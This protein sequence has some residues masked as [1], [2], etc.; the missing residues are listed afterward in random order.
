MKEFAREHKILLGA[1]ISGIL[2]IVFFVGIHGSRVINPLDTGLCNASGW[3][4]QDLEQH[5]YGWLAFRNAPWTFP[6]GMFDTVT[7][8][9][10]VSMI[11]ADCIPL[12]AIIGKLFS[13]VLPAQFQYFGIYGVLCY[14]LI[15]LI[16]YRILNRYTKKT[17]YS[18][19]GS[20]FFLIAPI[21]LHRTMVHEALASQWILLWAIDMLLRIDKNTPKKKLY[22]ELALLSFFASTIHMYYVLLCGVVLVGMCIKNICEEKSVRKTL[23]MLSIY[24]G[25]AAAIIFSL[26]GF[27][28]GYETSDPDMLGAFNANL[29]TF[30][31]P[32][33]K[34]S[35]MYTQPLYNYGQVDGTGYLGV[36][37]IIA[38]VVAVAI[39]FGGGSAKCVYARNITL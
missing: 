16:S 10:K 1:I 25:E 30:I 33:S 9:D 18:I 20:L 17:V 5:Y 15:A 36:G 7:Y 35:I 24:I 13:F 39:I 31:N 34:S 29:D 37:V 19:I 22:G 14:I 26:G 23:T 4:T 3:L 21:L 2:A 6:L 32:M 38:C 12:L 28:S 27:S 8:P 11:F